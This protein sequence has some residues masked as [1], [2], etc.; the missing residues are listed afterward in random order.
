MP[1]SSVHSWTRF[2]TLTPHPGP[3]HEFTAF[4]QPCCF[5]TPSSGPSTDPSSAFINPVPPSLS[6]SPSPALSLMTSCSLSSPSCGRASPPLMASQQQPPEG[7]CCHHGDFAPPKNSHGIS[8]PNPSMAGAPGSPGAVQPPPPG[9]PAPRTSPALLLGPHTC[10][11]PWISSRMPSFRLLLKTSLQSIDTLKEN[12]W[13][14]SSVCT[15]PEDVSCWPNSRSF[16][17]GLGQENEQRRKMGCPHADL[18]DP[19]LCLDGALPDKR[20]EKV[21]GKKKIFFQINPFPPTPAPQCLVTQQI[22]QQLHYGTGL[23]RPHDSAPARR[24][25]S[26]PVRTHVLITGNGAGMTLAFSGHHK[27]RREVAM[28][29]DPLPPQPDLPHLRCRWSV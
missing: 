22:S 5:W 23:T 9:L 2:T 26:T 17:A 12:C 14:V 8:A 4:L 16:L 6:C 11:P 13:R 7:P 29:G 20:T 18:L 10:L 3:W 25:P 19:K 28:P 24:A 1:P 15:S 27:L 21:Q